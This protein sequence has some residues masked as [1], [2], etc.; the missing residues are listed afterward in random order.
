MATLVTP[1]TINFADVGKTSGVTPAVSGTVTA[2]PGNLE[3]FDMHHAVEKDALR[4]PLNFPVKTVFGVEQALIHGGC[5]LSVV[6]C[7]H[8]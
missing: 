1:G 2:C 7:T 6:M 4:G 3:L 8:C 5:F